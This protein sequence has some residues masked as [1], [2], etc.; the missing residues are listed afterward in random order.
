MIQE[1]C[2][3]SEKN[4][5]LTSRIIDP[6]MLQ[7]KC[8]FWIDG[9][10]KTG[11]HMYQFYH[12]ETDRYCISKSLGALVDNKGFRS[13]DYSTMTDCVKRDIY[14]NNTDKPVFEF[15]SEGSSLPE[16][17]TDMLNGPKD[18]LRVQRTV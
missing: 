15:E 6:F 16:A 11:S 9:S 8:V 10:C 18:Y 17:N 14:I 3:V 12:P 1:I 7:K 13:V 5:K 4:G 2:C